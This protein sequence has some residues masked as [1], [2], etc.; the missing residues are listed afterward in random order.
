MIVKGDQMMIQSTEYKAAQLG[1]EQILGYYLK[2][3]APDY[4]N[5]TNGSPMRIATTS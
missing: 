5:S 2:V 3:A 1:D 4:E